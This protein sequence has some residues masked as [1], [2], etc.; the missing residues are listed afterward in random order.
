[1]PALSGKHGYKPDLQIGLF[2]SPHWRLSSP[3]LAGCLSWVA[4]LPL[5][6]C[7]IQQYSPTSHP[8]GL[9]RACPHVL[10]HGSVVHS[11]LLF[12]QTMRI[13]QA[14][15]GKKEGLQTILDLLSMSRCTSSMKV[16]GPLGCLHME[17][18]FLITS[19]TELWWSGD[20][21]ARVFTLCWMAMR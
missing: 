11:G 19:H 18:D 9:A 17:A 3:H 20:T 2:Y 14:R 12:L 15:A 8:C 13:I 5:H 4:A 10:P 7:V 1:M 6:R 21:A 16:S